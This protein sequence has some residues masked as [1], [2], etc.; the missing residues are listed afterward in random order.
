MSTATILHKSL[1]QSHQQCPRRAWL[2]ADGK[3]QPQFSVAGE[4]ML[5]Q[6]K[7]VH[8][9]AR[10]A[11]VDAVTIHT[12]LA[13]PEAAAQTTLA[14]AGGAHTLIEAAFVAGN[15]GARVDILECDADGVHLNEVKSGSSLKDKYLD[16]VAI[17]FACLERAGVTVKTASITHPSTSRVLAESGAGASVLV[18]E[19]V[20]DTVRWRSLRVAA[21]LT[22]CADTLAGAEPTTAPGP[23]CVDPQPCPF[24]CHCGKV[25]KPTETDC[26]AYLPSKAGPV[27]ECIDAG[28]TKISELPPGA[29]TK[30][31]NA[32]VRDAILSGGP[33]VREGFSRKLASLGFPR[34]FL[35]FETA[36]SA[37][38]LHV[39]MR[40]F[41]ALPF[42]WSCHRVESVGQAPAHGWFL[43]TTGADPRRGF[44]ESV[45]AFVGEAG[46]V[47]VYSGYE[48]A[49]LQELAVEFPDL[50]DALHGVIARLVD[51][52]PL[53]RRGYYAPE[54]RGSWS[55][56]A[57][58]PTLPGAKAAGL[59]YE[60]LGDLSDGMAA[61]AAYMR[62][63]D[64]SYIGEDKEA[65]RGQ[66]LDYCAIDTAGLMFF[67]AY[68]ESFSRKGEALAA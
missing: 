25:A 6:G 12:G 14:I 58:L 11:L 52:L 64:A 55:I 37:I 67:F 47:L 66:L 35:D 23:Q 60:S 61:Q 48:K 56:K 32:L 22:E 68:V 46:P 8:A 63:I 7:M 65:T 5:E 41:E 28:I 16:D 17:Q 3:V 50:A 53:A 9:A 39:G 43:D 19:D 30:A 45:L 21:W 44:A 57:I 13:L 15:L 18:R 42:Q 59:C 27:A 1:V 31:R 54:Q 26:V 62:L 49:R 36:G 51:L 2:E 10:R 38:P 20:T 29:F 40:P 34:S 4:A 33:V 24:S